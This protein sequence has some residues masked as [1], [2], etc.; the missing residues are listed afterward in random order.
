MTSKAQMGRPTKLTDEL[1]AKATKYL[2]GGHLSCGDIVP[3]IAGLSRHLNVT[4]QTLY[5][6]GEQSTEFLD[7]LDDIKAEQERLLI[8]NGLVGDFNS[9]IAKL[10]L[11][12]HGYSDKQEI[13]NTSSDGSMTPHAPVFNLNPV[14]PK[15]DD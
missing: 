12:K 13:D 2:K 11:V 15:S 8:N 6:F 1:K 9:T 7:M 3:S 4:R 10:M 5:N 14:R